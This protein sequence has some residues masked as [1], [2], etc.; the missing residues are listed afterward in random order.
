MV[1]GPDAP[2]SGQA[3]NSWL[4][5]TAAWNYAA[6]TQFMLGIRAEQNGLRIAP[7]IASEIG[8]FQITRRCRGADYRISVRC[9]DGGAETG[10]FINGVRGDSDIIRYA[11]GGTSTMVECRV[12]G[13]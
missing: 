2:H 13:C 8:S 10:L 1:A 4:T 12:H 3:K 7:T 11:E 9:V 5:G 6:I